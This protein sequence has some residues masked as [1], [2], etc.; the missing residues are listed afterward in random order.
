[1]GRQARIEYEGAIYHVMSRGNHQ[2][3]TF[4][5][6]QDCELFL[7]TLGEA[8]DRTG[9]RVH[10]YVLMGNH[11][12]LL[13]ETPEANLV[14]GMRWLQSTYTKRFN[15]R[16]KEWGHLFQGRYKA[17]LVDSE[18]GTYFS[19]VASYV[20][21]NPVRVKGYD[22][23]HHRLEDHVWSSYP[24]YQ[25]RSLRP[26]WLSVDRVL[27]S[28][29]LQDTTVGRLTYQEY[30]SHRIVEISCSESPWEADSQWNEIRRGWYLGEMGFR[31]EL[32]E[33]LSAVVDGKRRDSY[34]G[35]DIR[36][37]DER[38]AEKLVQEGLK[39][40]GL[41]NEGLNVFRKG[42]ARKKVMAW[43]VR[44]KTSVKNEWI[45]T[46]LCMGSSSNLSHYI[47]IVEHADHGELHELKLLYNR[48]DT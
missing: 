13:L 44:R 4:R 25:D 27:G 38:E 3:P 7:K 9:W 16:H 33:R 29:G 37:H 28:L 18:A 12:H 41:Q 14:A 15:V 30:I 23:S 35:S 36:L 31:D 42:D 21:L 39:I 8:C 47:A 1:M 22:F 48:T 45:S 20:H 19:T 40:F 2:Q 34:S 46:R 10:A 26:D 17:L 24:S 11:Y 5:S 6:D 43:N 32:L